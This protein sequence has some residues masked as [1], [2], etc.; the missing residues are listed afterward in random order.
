[1]WIKCVAY[2]ADMTR[3]MRMVC[4]NGVRSAYAIAACATC[5]AFA[6]CGCVA[7]VR[8]NN[9]LS[10]RM[11][12]TQLAAVNSRTESV[13]VPLRVLTSEQRDGQSK[14]RK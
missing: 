5:R 3:M 6:N 7:V 12:C 1:M 14:R 13:H 11:L 10:F 9:R 4:V 2:D 8:S